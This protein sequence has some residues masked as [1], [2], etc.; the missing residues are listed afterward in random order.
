MS[1]CSSLWSGK[2]QVCCWFQ[3]ISF[4]LNL[5]VV[6]KPQKAPT[7]KHTSIRSVHRAHPESS[8]DKKLQDELQKNKPAGRANIGVRGRALSFC[9]SQTE[10]KHWTTWKIT[11]CSAFSRHNKSLH[12]LFLFVIR[13]MWSHDFCCSSSEC[14]TTEAW[15]ETVILQETSVSDLQTVIPKQRLT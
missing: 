13:S 10:N 3:Q 7:A 15:T 9:F 4:R 14:K 12:V 2:L 6:A 5:N 11:T 8:R 1:V